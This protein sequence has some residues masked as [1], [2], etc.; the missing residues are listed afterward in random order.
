MKTKHAYIII[1]K[2]VN[3]SLIFYVRAKHMQSD[4]NTFL[5]S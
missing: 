3:T 4:Y 2:T 5:I 1:K